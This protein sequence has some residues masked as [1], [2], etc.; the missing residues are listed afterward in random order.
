MV[1]GE[2]R[3]VLTKRVSDPRTIDLMISG[4]AVPLPPLTPERHAVMGEGL[5]VSVGGRGRSCSRG[6]VD[7][8]VEADR[9]RGDHCVCNSPQALVKIAVITPPSRQSFW[10]TGPGRPARRPAVHGIPNPRNGSVSA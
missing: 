10:G 3:E 4:G 1:I 6:P 5:P 7:Q 2:L 9:L 8:G